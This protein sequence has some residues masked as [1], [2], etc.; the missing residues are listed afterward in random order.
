MNDNILLLFMS[1]DRE[2]QAE[3]LEVPMRKLCVL[4]NWVGQSNPGACS[5]TM[6][7]RNQSILVLAAVP[8]V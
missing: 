5:I 6:T 1:L 4:A 7:G 3:S 8:V 2:T